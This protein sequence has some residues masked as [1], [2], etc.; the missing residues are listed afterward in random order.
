VGVSVAIAT[1]SG[2]TPAVGE[3]AAVPSPPSAPAAVHPQPCRGAGALRGPFPR[4][5]PGCRGPGG[6]SPKLRDNMVRPFEYRART[7]G[8]PT[9]AL[10]FCI[11]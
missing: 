8:T 5:D 2:A 1:V 7:T 4:L 10:R 9:L 11:C 6:P 3:P